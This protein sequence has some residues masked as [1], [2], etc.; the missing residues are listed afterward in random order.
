MSMAVAECHLDDQGRGA[1]ER[2]VLR[3]VERGT[4]RA[5]T[6]TPRSCRRFAW[7]FLGAAGLVV[8][9]ALPI[10]S[11]AGV[12][13]SPLSHAGSTYVVRPGD[14]IRSIA[15]RIRPADPQAVMAAIASRTGS[16]SVVPG[17]H[18]TVP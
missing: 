9:L 4:V 8:G 6:A 10:G 16:S 12:Q 14:T 17:E 7:A 13:G 2:P 5:K 3:L 18:L 15:T 1:V 11:L